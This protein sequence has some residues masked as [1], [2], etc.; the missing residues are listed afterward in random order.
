MG[1]ETR[2][3]YASSTAFYLKDKAEEQPWLTRLP[4]PV[5]LLERL[6]RYDHVA[7]TR[8]VTR[9]RYHHGFYDGV[10][11]EYRGFAYVEQWDAE[12]FGVTGGG[13]FPE[14]ER[15]VEGQLRLPPVRTR[16]WFHT[17]AWLERER[18]ERALAK[19]YYGADTQAP[20]LIQPPLP[21]RLSIAEEREA[22]RALRGSLLRQESYAEDGLPES[23]HPYSVTEH[24]H[25][26]RLVLRDE[27]QTRGEGHAH[28]VFFVHAHEDLVLYYERNPEDPRVQ[29]QLTLEVDDFGNVLRAAALAYPRRK[30]LHPEQE[31]LWAT[32]SEATFVNRVEEESWYRIGVPVGSSTSELT[33]LPRGSFFT[34]EALLGLVAKAAEISFEVAPDGTLERRLVSR[35]RRLYY[36]DDVRGPLPLGRINTRALPFETYEQAFTPGLLAH[37]CGDGVDDALLASE[38][39]YVKDDGVWW[40][41][42]GRQVFDPAAFYQ[43]V[44]AIDAFGERYHVRYDACALLVI[45]TEDPLENKVTAVND[46]RVLAP[47]LVTDANGNRAA[48][49]FDAL[50]MPVRIALMGKEGGGEGDSLDDPTIHI[51]YDLHRYLISH[52]QQPVSVRTLSRER[53]GAD[54]LRW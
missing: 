10:E 13:L 35:Q 39:G 37:A 49:A 4:F 40:A 16:T 9:Y 24:T 27:V 25:A 52:G 31:R 48:A 32:L 1:G 21:A 33:G 3:A 45:E 46:L 18:L 28:A 15:E 11:R 44:S 43:P 26:V 51:D 47:S 6:E 41:P 30:P 53:H 22:A 42:S 17:G 54:N 14:A 36:R 20:R 29:H 12:T 38:G 19:D 2:L 34:V 7:G 8:L 23:A 5:H 50:G